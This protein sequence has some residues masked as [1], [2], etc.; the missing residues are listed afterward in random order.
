MAAD[1]L[2]LKV[3]NLKNEAR[4]LVEAESR[5]TGKV[6]KG[7]TSSILQVFFCSKLFGLVADVPFQGLQEDK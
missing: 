6:H 5:L 3:D 1:A 2:T 4:H 7:S